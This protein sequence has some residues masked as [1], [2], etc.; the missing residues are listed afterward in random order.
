MLRKWSSSLDWTLG[1]SRV[2]AEWEWF[3]ASLRFQGGVPTEVWG[4]GQTP[5][6]WR[7]QDKS[8]L[9]A[10]RLPSPISSW[11]VLVSMLANAESTPFYFPATLPPVR[12]NFLAQPT[13][14][15]ALHDGSVSWD[16]LQHMS[17]DEFR[18]L[19]SGLNVPITASSDPLYEL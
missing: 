1:A 3:V 19:H 5:A 7:S 4:T 17:Y 12:T 16:T 9:T 14:A 6:E 10:L 15:P 11:S 2:M 18:L 13:S 8:N